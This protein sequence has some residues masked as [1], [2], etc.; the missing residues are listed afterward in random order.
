MDTTENFDRMN[1]QTIN[2]YLPVL[3]VSFFFSFTLILYGAYEIFLLNSSNFS[4]GFADFWYMIAIFSFVIFMLAAVLGGALRGKWREFYCTA[5]FGGTLCG[6][7]QTMVLNGEMY[8]LTGNNVAWK[9][10]TVVLNLVSWLVILAV[11]FLLHIKLKGEWKRLRLFFSLAIVLMQS[12]ALVS[13]L[14]TKD[15]N[16]GEGG[17]LSETGMLEVSADENVVFFVVDYFDGV[18]MEELLE[19]DADY[20]EPLEGFTYFP[21]ATSMYSRTFPSIPYLLTGEKFYFDTPTKE[22]LDSA[23][24]KS[25]FWQDLVEQNVDIGLYTYEEYLGA[26]AKEDISNYVNVR[27]KPDWKSVL[28][29]M[30]KMSFYRSAPYCVKNVFRYDA[31]RINNSILESNQDMEWVGRFQNGDDELFYEKLGEGLELTESEKTF[32]FY[33]LASCHTDLTNPIPNGKFSLEI[34]YEYIRQ[35]KELG[36][37]DKTTIIIAA[38]HGRSG[39]GDTLDLPQKTAVPVMIVK[40]K[41]GNEGK[42]LVVSEAPVS[43]TDL[44][45]TILS[46]FGCEEEKFSHTVFDFEEGQDR[47][48]LYYYTALYSDQEG[49]I[50]LREYRISG[51]ARETENYQFTGKTWEIQHSLNKVRKD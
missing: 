35:L 44:L 17:Y 49:E 39:G 26:T 2:S 14:F 6:Y 38:D 33:H 48:R 43:H 5:L 46:G 27:L 34:I 32:R 3:T 23:Y 13:L 37:Y 45:G 1:K 15:L 11:C 25:A 47:E 24:E 8:S 42:E 16:T 28:R 21:N 40:P 50:E 10:S 22:Y 51:D 9:S 18:Y 31:D 29:G 41:A 30:L 4:F 7:V 36:V 12:V 19:E 20:L